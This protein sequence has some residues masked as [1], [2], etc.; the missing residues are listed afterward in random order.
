MSSDSNRTCL[1][2]CAATAAAAACSCGAVIPCIS[3]CKY[4]DAGSSG[5]AGGTDG[6]SGTDGAGGGSTS[7]LGGG[8]EGDLALADPAAAG[9]GS[10]EGD[11]FSRRL[12][13]S[14]TVRSER[15]LLQCC[16][17]AVEVAGIVD[18]DEAGGWK[19]ERTLKVVSGVVGFTHT[20]CDLR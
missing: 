5:G 11:G 13:R 14:L 6:G 18:G 17:A 8:G 16:S 4:A 2:C 20:L 7:S 19:E 3:C 1:T 15:M 9:A 10:V 12:L